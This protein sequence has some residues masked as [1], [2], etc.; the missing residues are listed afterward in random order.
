MDDDRDPTN[1]QRAY[2]AAWD[3]WVETGDEAVWEIALADGLGE[4]PDEPTDAS[5]G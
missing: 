1:L 3:E 4:Y 2:A 5:P